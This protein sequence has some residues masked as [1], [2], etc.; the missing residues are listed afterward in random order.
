MSFPCVNCD[1]ALRT[2]VI[3]S[4]YAQVVALLGSQEQHIVP[5]SLQAESTSNVIAALESHLY[6]YVLE[7]VADLKVDAYIELVHD[8][9]IRG[10]DGW[11]LEDGYGTYRFWLVNPAGDNYMLDYTFERGEANQALWDI[12]NDAMVEQIELWTEIWF[13]LDAEDYSVYTE[14]SLNE[15][16]DILES[17]WDIMWVITATLSDDWMVDMQASFPTAQHH[18]ALVYWSLDLNDELISKAIDALECSCSEG[19]EKVTAATCLEDGL[20]LIECKICNKELDSKVIPATGHTP[21]ESNDILAPTCTAK[22]AWEIR[23]KECEVVLESGE[24][25]ALGH[26]PGDRVDTLAPNCTEKGAWEIRCEE[27]DVVLDSGDIDE[28]GHK[29]GEKVSTGASTCVGAGSWEIRCIICD[30]LVESGEV[31]A[32]GHTPGEKIVTL[33]PTCT[34]EGAWEIRCEEC[35]VVLGS[36][37]LEALG[38]T[39]G[40]LVVTKA[41]T[42]TE[43]GA[44]EIR[45]IVCEVLLDS[46]DIDTLKVVSA[47]GARFISIAETSK[48]S[49]TWALTFD[50]TVTLEDGTTEN[51]R[52]THNLNGNNANLDGRFTFGAGHDL[53]GMTLTYDI[54]GNGSNIKAFS[55]R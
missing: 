35:D 51:V 19:E 52:Y 31:D 44:W 10:E 24:I 23:C 38:H 50:V 42:R 32:L 7:I 18:P 6:S 8:I 34:G 46:G 27:C 5:L 9:S 11:I 54:K 45:C 39:H 17:Y 2:E 36:G 25:D 40:D 3:P 13:Y 15:A 22:G 41:A 55:I 53:A 33:D 29:P 49:R 26:T 48:N 43:M 1:E 47:A 30:S 4:L 20:L 12:W 21:G 28:L 37:E 14:E 16:F